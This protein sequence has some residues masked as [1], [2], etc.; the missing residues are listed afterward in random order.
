MHV[1]ARQQ[2]DIIIVDLEGRLVSGTSGDQLLQAVMNEVVAEA[3]MKIVINLAKV[4]HIDSAGVG[5]LVASARLAERFGSQVKVVKGSERVQ[6]VLDVGHILPLLSVFDDET[7]AI[8]SF[9]AMGEAQ[10]AAQEAE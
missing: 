10:A 3:W 6:H 1:D 9:A 4:T 5:E 2:G 8:A 7:T